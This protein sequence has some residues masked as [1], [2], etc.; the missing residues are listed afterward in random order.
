MVIHIY[1]IVRDEEQILP[2]F[3][4]HY[5]TF[6]NKIFILD[7]RSVD[8]TVE[9]A[10]TNDKVQLLDFSQYHGGLH[11]PEHSRAF[12]ESYKKYSRG[13]ADW[14]MCVDADE[15]IYHYDIRWLLGQKQQEGQRI[16]KANGITMFS[17]HYPATNG[18]IYEECD[19]GIRD[20]LYDKKV[21]FDPSIDIL[22]DTG[23]HETLTPQGKPYQNHR[24][25][26][27]LLHYRYLDRESTVKHL[28]RSR[29]S[30]DDQKLAA[31][32]AEALE[33]YEAGLRGDRGPL[34]KVIL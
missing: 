11:E 8:R 1:S 18:Q 6:A 9:I 30:W 5:S 28:D 20:R 24:C 25:N 4:K 13:S 12:I 33:R 17:E 15:F 23:R 2:Y 16:L 34:F 10:R 21:I 19:T 3:L 31:R 14:V 22:F 29:Y 27:L 32:K 7:D 26:I